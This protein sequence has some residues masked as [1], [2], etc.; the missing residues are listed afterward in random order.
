MPRG[1]ITRVAAVAAIMLLCACADDRLSLAPP[2]SVD[3]SGTW[4][5]NEADSD[6]TSHLM[7]STA[8]QAG[9]NP[10]GGSGGGNSGGRGGRGG[11][12]AARAPGFGPTTPSMGALGAGLRWPGKRLVVKQVAGVVAFTS[13][14]KN[15]VCQPSDAAQ[16]TPRHSES[17]D[18][19]APLPAAREAPPPVCG[20]S[21]KTL[22][23]RSAKD[24]DDDRPPFEER[25]SLSDDGQRLIEVVGFKG[26]NSNGFTASRVWDRVPQP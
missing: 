1:S 10:A 16:K 26:G 5:L 4:Q 3:F 24:P 19:D 20:W 6:D 2:A 17:S 23:V 12:P 21:D 18:R 9:G 8:A 22:I 15:R 25:Y 13:D 11:S 7:Q 14:G